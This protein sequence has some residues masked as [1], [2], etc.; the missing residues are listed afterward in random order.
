MILQKKIFELMKKINEFGNFKINKYLKKNMIF[1]P[2]KIDLEITTK[3]NLKCIFCQV[4]DWDR[5]KLQ[6]MSFNKFKYILDQI[7][8]LS[9]IKLQGMGESFLNKDIFKMI[10]FANK[11]GIK[12]ET[13]TNGTIL[14]K[15]KIKKLFKNPPSKISFSLDTPN[16]ITY[17]KLRGKNM[18]NDIINNIRLTIDE[19]NKTKSNTKIRIWCILNKYNID[20]VPDLIR[21]AKK[22]TVDELVIQTK[23]SSFGKLN[24]KDKNKKIKVNVFKK[25]ILS[26]LNKAKEFAKKKELKLTVFKEN[27][28][29]KTDP[30]NFIKSNPYISVEG[31]IVPC[32]I[33]AD[34]KIISLGNIFK[35][36]FTKIWNNKKYKQ[37]RKAH[38]KNI[39]PN[40]CKDCYLIK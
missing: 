28:F 33:I 11:K 19:K 34:P 3:C 4:P 17:K 9:L 26:K 21:L 24:L 16:N 1:Q 35:E 18:F 37:L 32:C 36:K 20:Q 29:T 10:E 27:Y 2:S 8:F 6:D 39:L 7:P 31:E 14:S 13:T 12:I 30:C 15:E 5:K 25:E 23:I 38:N 40:F 22:L